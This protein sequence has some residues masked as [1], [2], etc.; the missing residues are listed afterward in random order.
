MARLDARS[1]LLVLMLLV[2]DRGVM[3][4]R[5]VIL[6]RA[7]GT[8]VALESAVWIYLVSSFLGSFLPAGIGGDAARAYTLARRTAQGGPAVASVAVDRLLGLLS[9]VSI[10]VVGLLVAGPGHV[11]GMQT[12]L[13]AL[14]A[15]SVVALTTLLWADRWAG[16]LVPVGPLSRLAEALGQYR[17]HRIALGAVLLLSVAVQL[18]RILQA[19]LLGVGI[20]IDV[21]FSY[22]LLFMPVGLVALML[23]ISLNGFGLPQG[24]IVW[25]LQPVNVPATDA[26]ALSTLIVLSG[27]IANVPGGWLYLRSRQSPREAAG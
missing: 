25:L 20:G 4:W 7:T 24:V 26:F 10:A 17:G 14:C 21:P 23:P 3:V 8:P 16:S 12:P 2:V 27:I 18:L 9:I 5:W 6:L 1:A 22:Y 15:A 11:E 19:W 13:L